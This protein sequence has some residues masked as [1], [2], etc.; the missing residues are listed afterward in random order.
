[1]AS[2][3]GDA[4]AGVSI[5][6]SKWEKR[7]RRQQLEK[8]RERRVFLFARFK[9][10]S[11]FSSAENAAFKSRFASEESSSR[12]SS[13]PPGNTE[14]VGGMR[15]RI[16]GEGANGGVQR[17]RRIVSEGG[18]KKRGEIGPLKPVDAVDICLPSWL[19][20]RIS[21]GLRRDS[22][23]KMSFRNR[24]KGKRRKNTGGTE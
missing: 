8:D 5:F 15:E 9:Q 21:R 24:G 6:S 19:Y 23:L 4:D 20:R 2:T 14:M 17:A 16:N 7:R 3:R 11:R 22:L 1:M 18:R 12:F 13:F 10:P